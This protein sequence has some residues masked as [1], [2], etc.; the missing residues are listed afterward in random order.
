MGQIKGYGCSKCNYER[1]FFIGSGM[2]S[3]KKKRLFQCGI[4]KVL[5]VSILKNP[6]CSKCRKTL[7]LVS[8]FEKQ[9]LCPK[10]NALSFHNVSVGL[11]D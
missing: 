8:D 4:C 3:K 11:W 7:G 6:N 10:C 9:F 1:D 5:K 2:L